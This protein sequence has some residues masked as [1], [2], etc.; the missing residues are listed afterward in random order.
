MFELLVSLKDE[1]CKSRSIM[2]RHDTWHETASGDENIVSVMPHEAPYAEKIT[3]E[4]I[5][6]FLYIQMA[7]SK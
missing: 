4:P 5:R 6:E 7:R 3:A 1:G 2:Q